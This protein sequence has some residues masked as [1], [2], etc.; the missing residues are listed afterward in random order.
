MKRISLFII[1]SIIIFSCSCGANVK[2]VELQNK[3]DD[4]L[5]EVSIKDSLYNELL[6]AKDSIAILDSI[7]R[8]NQ[9]MLEDC[10]RELDTVSCQNCDLRQT[11][12]VMNYK[13]ERIKAYC[14]IVKKNSSQS[15]Y[16]RGWINRV[17]ED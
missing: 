5:K 17:L 1:S 7:N 4:L 3:Y 8:H 11:L 9:F 12:L 2:L 13:F 6:S 15:V 16:L 10:Q 14:D